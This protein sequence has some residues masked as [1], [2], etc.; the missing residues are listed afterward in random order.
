VK[1]IGVGLPRTATLSQKIALEMLGFGP[2]YHMV[3]ALADLPQAELWN[4]AIAGE[5]PWAEIFDGYE[6]TVDWPGGFF[7]EELIELYPDAKVLLSE[8][9]P[10]EWERSM[11]QTVWDVRHGDSVMRKLS[12]AQGLVYPPWAGF[13]RMVDGLLWEGRGTFA[14]GHLDDGQLAEGMVRHHQAVKRTVPPE[15]LL[16]WSVSEGWEPL[17]EFL[18][19]PAPHAPFPRV[20][21][22]KEFVDRVIDGSLAVLNEWR[23]RAAAQASPPASR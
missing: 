5:A 23:S 3:T 4:R 6:S 14:G 18:E 20:N 8:R 9:D 15:R 1:L 16:T 17:C 10:E 11:R 12:D 13:L 7:Y 21:D 22:T 2:C 19:V